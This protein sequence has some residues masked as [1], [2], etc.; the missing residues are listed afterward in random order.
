MATSII[1]IARA[2]GVSRGTVIRALGGKGRISPETKARVLKVAAELD[3]RPNTIARSLV[4]GKTRV[5]GLL[6]GPAD[7]LS[8]N[9]YI[10]LIYRILHP[11]RYSMLVHVAI[12][13]PEGERMA[14]DEM[15]CSR[16]SGVLAQPS[17]L[18]SDPEAYRQLLT[19]GIP[20]VMFD[21]TLDGFEVPQVTVDQYLLGRTATEYLISLGHRRIVHF[22]IPGA[23][24]L[25]R[26]RIRGFTDAMAEAGLAVDDSSI[27]EVG[28]FIEDGAK[29]MRELL[30]RPGK[31]P[32]AIVARHDYV[33]IGAIAAATEAGLSVPGDISVIGAS[34]V[35][36]GDRLAVPLTTL[37]NPA[38][39]IAAAATG[40]LLDM[41]E[42]KTVKPGVHPV[43]DVRLVIRES[44]APPRSRG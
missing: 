33:A 41:L 43:K 21:R 5:I 31:T 36:L 28:W 27:I 30:K 34:D 40:Y 19:A 13:G 29:A 2:S 4:S 1:D 10:D 24:Y 22:A 25:S 9:P 7:T 17:P 26:E 42:G 18:S 37:Y 35:P 11:A 23:Q 44:C 16:V 12:A 15:I 14:V 39:G 3:Y 20:L 32:T 6:L 38:K 8:G